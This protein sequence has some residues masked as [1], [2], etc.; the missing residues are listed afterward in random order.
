[1]VPWHS[2]LRV[3]QRWY[4]MLHKQKNKIAN[5]LINE[6]LTILGF[7]I[8]ILFIVFYNEK[9]TQIQELLHTLLDDEIEFVNYG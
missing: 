4:P 9:L 1:M 8:I 7:T 6:I 3:G 5:R 2:I